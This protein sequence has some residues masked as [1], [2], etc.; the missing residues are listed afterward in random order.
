M[1]FTSRGSALHVERGHG[2]IIACDFACMCN[3]A[4]VG[5]V[6]VVAFVVV[7]ITL[8]DEFLGNKNLEKSGYRFEKL[9]RW[10]KNTLGCG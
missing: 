4:N 7:K 6:K 3:I 2:N 10:K 8:N 1:L 5:V 9:P